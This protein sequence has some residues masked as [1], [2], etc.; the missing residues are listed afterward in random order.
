MIELDERTEKELP[1]SVRAV[2]AFMQQ[3]RIDGAKQE[4]E[5]HARLSR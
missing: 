3:T 4:D 5:N 2:R 1:Q